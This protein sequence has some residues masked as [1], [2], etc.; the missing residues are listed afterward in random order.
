MRISGS[1]A[2]PVFL[3]YQNAQPERIGFSPVFAY[4]IPQA[5][6][7]ADFKVM[8]VTERSTSP[9]DGDDHA[10]S[11]DHVIGRACVATRRRCRRDDPA[12]VSNTG[13]RQGCGLGWRERS[14]TPARRRWQSASR[15]SCCRRSSRPPCAAL[16]MLRW[17]LGL[18]WPPSFSPAALRLCLLAMYLVALS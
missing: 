3:I 8:A 9:L 4:P 5:G 17:Q 10:A 11:E 2:L 13:L 14:I 18:R 6:H 16:A 7:G 1:H 15:K 12:A